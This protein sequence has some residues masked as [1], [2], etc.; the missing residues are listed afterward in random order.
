MKVLLT[1]GAGY[2]GSHIAAV[3]LEKG[4]D[5]DNLEDQIAELSDMM[6]EQKII[7]TSCIRDEHTFVLSIMHLCMA[8]MELIGA[9]KYALV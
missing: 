6:K 7:D 9:A 5:C 1:G 4:Y 3:L 2:I 8:T